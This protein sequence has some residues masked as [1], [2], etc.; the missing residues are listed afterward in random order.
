MKTANTIRH[1]TLALLVVTAAGCSSISGTYPR[2]GPLVPAA[3]LQVTEGYNL[4]LEKIVTYAGVAAVAYMVLDPFAPN[5]QI[6][7]AKLAPDQY[8]LQMRMKRFHTGGDGEA[9]VVFSRRAARLAREGGFSG[10]EIVNYSEGVESTL[11]A[12]RVSEGVIQLVARNP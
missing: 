7:E 1:F 12:Q 2:S 6:E 9:R 3:S 10:Y 4:P 5:W 8:L 11:I